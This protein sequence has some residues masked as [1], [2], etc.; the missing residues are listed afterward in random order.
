MLTSPNFKFSITIFL[1][2]MTVAAMLMSVNHVIEGNAFL[3]S[4]YW[5]FWTIIAVSRFWTCIYF[6]LYIWVGLDMTRLSTLPDI[7]IYKAAYFIIKEIFMWHFVCYSTWSVTWAGCYS[8]CFECTYI[9]SCI[10]AV[11]DM[12][13]F[14]CLDVLN[15]YEANHF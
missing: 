5:P 1:V 4:G 6:L 15:S 3:W 9:L 2:I 10:M 11:R 7:R 14:E 8:G 13:E 12:S